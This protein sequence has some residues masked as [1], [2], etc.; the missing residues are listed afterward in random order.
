[1]VKIW[2]YKRFS[3]S[4]K[5]LARMLNVKRIVNPVYRV[6]R[7]DFIINWGSSKA[8]GVRLNTTAAIAK[9]TDKRVALKL[10]QDA[11]V[12]VPEFTTD[13]AVAQQWIDDERRV[14]VRQLANSHSGRGASV[15]GEG[16]LPEA[17][18]Y[19]R[20]FRRDHEFRVHVFKGRVIDHVRKKRRNGYAENPN[21]NDHIRT[22]S[23]C[24]VFCR[25]GVSLPDGVGANAI[26][27]VAALGLDFGAVDVLYRE[28]GEKVAV[29]EVNT[30][31]GLEGQTVAKYAAAIKEYMNTVP[32]SHFGN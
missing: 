24:W 31:P 9:A 1:M 29:L 7:R 28:R 22:H 17:P 5:V 26:R 10:M 16:Q 23:N 13:R 18:L 2:P 21:H 12:A 27:A 11:G 3:S 4:A 6:K 8:Q 25:E 14:V 15:V 32:R 19:T 20:Y 30:A